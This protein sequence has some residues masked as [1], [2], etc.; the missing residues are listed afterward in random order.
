MQKF[1]HNL[2]LNKKVYT[3]V[4]IGFAF[5]ILYGLLKPPVFLHFTDGVTYA[6][7]VCL[8]IG[9]V[10]WI[11]KEGEFSRGENGKHLTYLE[12]EEIAKTRK[13]LPNDPFYAG[14]LLMIVATILTIIYTH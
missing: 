12:K 2:L 3:I 14:V 11:W 4:I 7:V 5:A 1:I 13:D 10:C 9:L 6:A 8:T